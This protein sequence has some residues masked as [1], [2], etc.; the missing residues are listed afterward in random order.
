[1]VSQDFHSSPHQ[2]FQH[3]RRNLSMSGPFP[4]P[5]FVFPARDPD[6]SK[7][8]P[9]PAT[10]PAILGSRGPRTPPSLPAFSFNPGSVQASQPSPQHSPTGPST[11]RPAGHRRRPSEFVGGDRLVTPPVAET[12]QTKD[13][14]PLQCPEKLP[15]PGPGFSAGGPGKRGR[16]AHRRSAAVSSVDLTAISNALNM[17]P[18]LGSAPVVPADRKRDNPTFD[19]I[20][21]PMSHSATSLSRCSP[22][23][24]PAGGTSASHPNLPVP[25]GLLAPEQLP[26][27][28]VPA[29]TPTP[30][31]QPEQATR[32]SGPPAIEISPSNDE[33]PRV[34]PKTADASWLFDQSSSGAAGNG[35]Q[36]KR[37]LLSTGHTRHKS[38]SS[39][40]LDA[41][42]K[43][44]NHA[45][46]DAHLSDLSGRSSSSDDDS[47]TSTTENHEEFAEQPSKKKSKSKARK[48]KV[49]SWAGSILTRGKGKRNPSKKEA[50]E[51]NS[52]VPPLLTR[53]NSELGSGLD[54][55][56]DDDNMVVLRA[57]TNT[58]TPANPPPADPGVP[59]PAPSL[60]SS[61]KPR[62]FYEQD[63][64]N[65]T[66][67]PVIDLDAAL[68][69]FN[70]PDMNAG[71]TAGSSFSAATKR[72]YSGGRRGEFV[73][74]E[75]RYHR[76]AESAPEMPPFDRGAL[77]NHRLTTNSTLENPDVFYEEEEDAFLAAT[78]EPSPE[79]ER[80]VSQAGS[81][82]YSDEPS[83]S[84][85]DSSDTVTQQPAEEE[86]PRAEG[87]GIQGNVP[88]QVAAPLWNN[89]D[90]E[91]FEQGKV[92]EQ[93]HSARNPFANPPRTPVDVIRQESWQHNRAPAPPSPDVSPRFLP[94]DKRPSTSPVDL[95]PNIPPFSL[96]GG[97][98]QPT[99]GFPSPIF[100]NSPPDGPRSVTT[101]STMDRNFFI[102]PY[103]NMSAEFPHGSV[104]DV[105]S[106][107]SS[108]STS[109]NPLQRFSATFFPRRGSSDRAASFSAAVHRRT[110]ASH[111]AK[112]SSLASLS[113]LVVG[114]HA[115]E[116]SKLSY[117]EKPPGDVPEKGKKKG[118]GIGR[119]KHFW[120]TKDKEKH[121]GDTD[122]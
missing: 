115:N 54:V 72:M 114:P 100:T 20:P 46:E 37:P 78:S 53:T 76:R 103:N 35:T 31:I 45:N 104:E 3:N 122:Q 52:P 66:L 8:I 10:S 2:V 119:L 91:R 107:T 117:E 30:A 13:E 14:K 40:L 70:T 32:N 62:S 22:P 121:H 15:A 61:W 90:N 71:Q 23:A 110:S 116:R 58:E 44:K 19:E 89:L 77:G 47:D 49:R 75:M 109:T 92:A 6:H 111:A 43:K 69:P 105:P 42:L 25:G 84:N 7:S 112:R 33:K 55:D 64:P 17:Q 85:K 51:D 95:V 113:K 12:N 18:T 101:P 16:H 39:G 38:L 120:R 81:V 1:M 68:G 97:S 82:I 9:P 106:L 29:E 73:G 96:H 65:D 34:R 36:S 59:Q 28:A 108:T 83:T 86:G 74:P 99:S 5:P 80:R 56:F 98:S 60:E 102:P 87:L 27:S 11:N 26:S 93:V 41:A 94:A 21:R 48:K 57:P 79:E 63:L 50:L 67:T 118:R 88:A 4:N 24:S